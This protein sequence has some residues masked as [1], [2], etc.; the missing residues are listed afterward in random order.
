MMGLETEKAGDKSE[1][2]MLGDANPANRL[3]RPPLPTSNS[4]T[5]FSSSTHNVETFGDDPLDLEGTLL[6]SARIQ[7]SS[8]AGVVIP[9][10]SVKSEFIAL[11]RKAEGNAK[12]TVTCLV[13]VQVPQAGRRESYPAPT[14]TRTPLKSSSTDRLATQRK[15][16]QDGPYPSTSTPASPSISHPGADNFSHIAADL[17]SR[18][19]DYKASGID[20]LG[21]IRLFD[22]LKVRKGAFVLDISVYLFQHALVC[23]TEEKKKSLRGFLNSPSSYSSLRH[24]SADRGGK[25]EKGVLKLK[26]RIYFKH[27]KRV[28]DTSV[29]GDLSLTITME[30]EKMDSFI[31]TFRDKDS[32]DLWRRSIIGA[33]QEIK[34]DH[35]PRPMSPISPP[36]SASGSMSSK[37]AKMG[38][39]DTVVSITQSPTNGTS[40]PLL[41]EMKT[42]GKSL[43]GEFGALLHSDT[44]LA[45][46]APPLLPIHTPIDLLIVCAIPNTATTTLHSIH[47]VRPIKAAFDHACQS[48]GP[49]DRISLVT[50]EHGVGGSVRKTQFLSPGR[51]EGR[52]K[53]ERFIAQIACRQEDGQDTPPDDFA[54]LTDK[55]V[56][57]DMISGINV[58]LDTVLQRKAKNPLTGVVLINDSG[59]VVKRAS[60]DL[61]LA[62][63]EAAK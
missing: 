40:S 7:H 33:V 2:R 3:R 54:V 14:V 23:V 8:S 26:G 13:T 15:E 42:P 36:T 27:V 59:E 31:L 25:K 20:S 9:A 12:Q 56:K 24:P 48:L 38:F 51:I 19:S 10:I 11:S 46:S 30:D 16:S 37:L 18:M 61:V 6:P 22:I 50:Y 52:K 39:N 60:M 5:S 32:M 63:A 34:G 47:K 21:R 58:G 57:T 41:R 17:K 55:E 49:G 44:E 53:L 43:I 1:N 29:A 62:R 4:T 35:Q 45:C 28:L